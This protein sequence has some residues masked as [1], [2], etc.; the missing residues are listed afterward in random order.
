MPRRAPVVFMTSERANSV[1]PNKDARNANY[2]PIVLL[3]N[4]MLLGT[5]TSGFSFPSNYNT[6]LL[7]IEG[8]IKVNSDEEV[9]AN[10]FVLF[11]N[12]G[13]AFTI[14]ATEKA[15]VLVL[16]GEPINEPIAA[17]GPFVMNTKDEIADAYRDFYAGKYGEIKK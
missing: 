16:S 7:V 11:E 3:S 2:A 15:I 13:E 9:P 6:A 4:S 17:Q 5:A 8:N 12:N 1:L 14:E 10:N